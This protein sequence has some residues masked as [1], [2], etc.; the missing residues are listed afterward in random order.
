MK[1]RGPVDD[2]AQNGIQVSFGGNA[3][4]K[5]NAV[6]GHWYTPATLRGLRAALLPR[7]EGRAEDEQ[8]VQERVNV[9]IVYP[10]S[11]ATRTDVQER[12]APA[13]LSVRVHI[14]MTINV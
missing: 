5:G 9:C 11:P 14:A 1:G 12:P 10:D 6:S 2:I 4:V 7:C 13:G 8:S 3:T